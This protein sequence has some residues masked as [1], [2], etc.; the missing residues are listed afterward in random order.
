MEIRQ[1]QKAKVLSE[2]GP[3]NI[4]IDGEMMSCDNISF[5]AV[6]HGIKFVIPESV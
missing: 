6:S 1:C 2:A 4:S 5:E 3:M